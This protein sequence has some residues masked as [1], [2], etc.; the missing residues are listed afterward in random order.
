VSA[1]LLAIREDIIEPAG[2]SDRLRITLVE[3]A[4]TLGIA[5]ES[6]VKSSRASSKS[7]QSK[8]RAFVEILNRVEPWAGGPLAALAWYRSSGI[9]A[10]GDMTAEVLVQD[11]RSEELRRYLDGIA[12]GG[13]A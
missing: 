12:A 6:I 7:T 3:L 9:P 4:Q 1:V 2:L 5:R 11:G 13:Y 8:L 10:F